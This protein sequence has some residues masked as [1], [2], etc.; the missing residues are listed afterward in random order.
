MALYA[1]GLIET[2]GYATAVSAA[3]AALK[4]ASVELLGVERVIGVKGTL[5]VTIQLGGDVGA[6]RSAVE[7]GK[8]EAEKV[9]NVIA[10]HV[11]AR[12]HQ[13]VNDKILP[14]FSLAAPKKEEQK[15]ELASIPEAEK[16]A[17]KDA[18]FEKK[19]TGKASSKKEDAVEPPGRIESKTDTINDSTKME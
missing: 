9:G 6:V 12:T 10:T 11:I 19:R 14:L 2:E 16:A 17:P 1:L 18:A 15:N 8:M 3:D 5:G 7:A 4:A 13:E